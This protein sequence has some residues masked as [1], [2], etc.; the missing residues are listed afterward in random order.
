MLTIIFPIIGVILT[1]LIGLNILKTYIDN[2]LQ[3]KKE[4]NEVLF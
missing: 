1:N 2:R 3:I 4:Y